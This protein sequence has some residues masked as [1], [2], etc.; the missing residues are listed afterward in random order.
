M[1]S[2]RGGHVKLGGN[3]LMIQNILL[4]NHTIPRGKWKVLTEF[5][6]CIV[7]VKMSS[8]YICS[9]FEFVLVISGKGCTIN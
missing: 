6:R 4:M 2:Q 9:L 8:L 7:H 3:Y 1:L 5:R